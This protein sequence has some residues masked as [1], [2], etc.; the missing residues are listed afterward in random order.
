VTAPFVLYGAAVEAL[1]DSSMPFGALRAVLLSAQYVP[2]V[3]VDATYADVVGF[4]VLDANYTAGGAA[5]VETA[6][7]VGSTVTVKGSKAQWPDSVLAAFVVLVADSD[8]DGILQPDDPLV[9]YSILAG[10]SATGT[11]SLTLDG[12]GILSLALVP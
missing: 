11:K 8:G 9:C 2:N 5:V 1:T 4:E 10:G 12:P 6:E 3:N 7:R